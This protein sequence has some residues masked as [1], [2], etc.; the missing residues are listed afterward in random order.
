M[1]RPVNRREPSIQCLQGQPLHT[2]TLYHGDSLVPPVAS[3]DVRSRVGKDQLVEPPW[4]MDSGPHGN[5]APERKPAKMHALN[6]EVIY[7]Q[8]QIAPE[9]I[10]R[11][12]RRRNAAF[13]V[14]SHVVAKD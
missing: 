11:V 10:E 2:G 4:G 13:A 7:E 3:P 8:Q 9:L 6:R 1:L 5:L 14:T 12:G